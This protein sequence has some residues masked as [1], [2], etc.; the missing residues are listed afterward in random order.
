MLAAVLR[1]T[2][3][4]RHRGVISG[5]ALLLTIALAAALADTQATPGATRN[6]GVRSAHAGS[7]V[8]GTVLVAFRRGTSR[9]AARRIVQRV[10]AT[11]AMLIGVGVNVLRFHQTSVSTAIA[12]LRR[13]REVRYAEPDYVLRASAAPNVPNDPSFGL[14]WGSRNLGRS[15][16]SQDADEVLGRPVSGT[17]GDDDKASWAWRLTVG[18]RAVVIGEVDT[19]IDYTHP[20]LAANIWSNPGGVGG[21]AAG[22]RGYNVVAGTCDP[23]DDDTVYGG[24]G[25][26]VAGIIG[27]VGNNGIGVAGLNW[28]TTILPVKWLNSS[29]EGSTDQ[30]ISALDWLVKAK[31]AGVN[32]RVVNDSATFVGTA[33]SQALSD[34]IDLL[35][36]NDILFVTAAGN[37]GQDDDDPSTPRYPCN[38]ERPTEICVT[39]SD[40]ND[41]LPSWA[42]YGPATVDLAAPGASVY[43]TLRGGGYGY[44]SGGSMAA[45]Q[46]SGAA[47]LILSIHNMSATALKAAIL[48]N[49]DPIS[50]MSGRVRTGGR[51][52]VCKAIAGCRQPPLAL[53]LPASPLR[54]T[55]AVLNGR[56]SPQNT[57]TAYFF[58][59]SRNKRLR[60]ATRTPRRSAGSG[61]TSDHVSTSVSGLLPNTRYYFRLVAT[62]SVSRVAGPVLSFTTR[63]RTR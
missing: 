5:G 45:A 12:E 60:R 53:T 15:V 23:L 27:A 2:E 57:N 46:V 38:Y 19:G 37:S 28:Q 34:E 33:Y 42:N 31:Q 50:A 4:A 51:L 47:A 3:S 11:D 26:H 36:S 18:S 25:T 62:D 7:F 14:E 44:L 6:T 56:V 30:L 21:C 39:A 48:D 41:Q 20:D 55:S 43:S 61:P 1:A 58:V 54:R 35:G 63:A 10:G 59:F 17:R 8:S 29:A 52:N 16:P 9:G 49:V 22:T 24:H 40:E 32:V 13:Q